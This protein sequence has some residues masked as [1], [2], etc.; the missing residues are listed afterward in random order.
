MWGWYSRLAGC[1][2]P[3]RRV[4]VTSL[5][6]S[7]LK[8]SVT[9]PSRVIAKHSSTVPA[10]EERRVM[11][12]DRSRHD[13]ANGLDRVE[14]HYL[15]GLSRTSCFRSGGARVMSIV[16]VSRLVTVAPRLS[17]MPMKGTRKSTPP[18]VH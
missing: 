14:E 15:P 7:P 6:N 18:P 9:V 16:W 5:L 10:F 3:I 4:W 8:P 1:S 12:A 13:G 11:T 17:F 2:M